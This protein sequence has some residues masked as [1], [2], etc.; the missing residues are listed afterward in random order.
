MSEDLAYGYAYA[1][2]SRLGA[3]SSLYS[4]QGGSRDSALS[5]VVE[6]EGVVLSPVRIGPTFTTWG[7]LLRLESGATARTIIIGCDPATAQFPFRASIGCTSA[8][9]RA[10][11]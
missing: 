2:L 7:A 1:D 8:V 5:R 10:G 11:R 4:S 3:F 9:R 6:G